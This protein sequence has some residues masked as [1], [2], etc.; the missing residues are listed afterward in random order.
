MRH[1]QGIY[2]DYQASTPLDERVLRRLS[3]AFIESFANPHSVEHAMGW[4]AARQLDETSASIAQVIGADPDEIIFTSGATEA[5]NLA[6]LGLAGGSR[7]GRKRILVSTIEHRCVLESAVAAA[8]L[9]NVKVEAVPVKKTGELD[10]EYLESTLDDDVLFVS[11]MGVHNEIGTVQPLKEI[12]EM[13]HEVGAILHTDAAHALANGLF[14]V[15]SLGIDL[16]SFSG[17]KIYGPKGIGAL[18]VRRDLQALLRPMIYGGGQQNNIRSGTLPLPLCIAF[19]EAI[20][21]M[22]GDEAQGEFVRISM[23]RNHLSE[24]ILELDDSFSVNGA[25]ALARHPGN[26][27]VLLRGYSAEQVIGMLQ[28]MIA[29]STGSACSGGSIA[30]SHVLKAIGLTDAE[31]NSSIRFGVGRF[32][33]LNQVDE[34]IAH[35][36]NALARYER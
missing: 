4:Q 22:N 21:L 33:D 36:R 20:K 25:G 28:P 3:T 10:L 16:A 2:L 29:V 34:A 5:N 19:E 15:T 6:I 31:A 24:R 18:Y 14:N 8:E 1:Q 35:I 7:S 30:A 32:S 13:V 12:S 11:V 9:F 17:H 27:N 23:L 26:L